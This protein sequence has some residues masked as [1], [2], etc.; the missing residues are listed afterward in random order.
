MGGIVN[1]RREG[2]EA[3]SAEFKSISF[4]QAWT[5]T[6][7]VLQQQAKE[8]FELPVLFLGKSGK[9]PKARI[10]GKV[11]LTS[12]RRSG[13]FLHKAFRKFLAEAQRP[14]YAG[15]KRTVVFCEAP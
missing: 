15:V 12:F 11:A 3:A 13:I 7:G 6:P 4:E 2:G 14:I 10:A 9:T 8:L 1:S 5:P